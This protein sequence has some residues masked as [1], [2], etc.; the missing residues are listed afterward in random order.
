MKKY[1]EIKVVLKVEDTFEWE[2]DTDEFDDPTQ[3]ESILEDRAIE[4]MAVQNLATGTDYEV[5]KVKVTETE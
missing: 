3:I 5:V 2:V 4:E 1:Y